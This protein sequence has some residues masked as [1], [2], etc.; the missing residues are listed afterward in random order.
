MVYGED[1]GV[2]AT[3]TSKKD[4]YL[5]IDSADRERYI[6]ILIKA[7]RIRDAACG[8][9]EITGLSSD[10]AMIFFRGGEE[11]PIR[12]LIRKVHTSY[13]S[14]RRTKGC[15]VQF[16]SAAYKLIDGNADIARTIKEIRGGFD[17]ICTS[18]GFRKD[19]LP[20]GT[21]VECLKLCFGKISYDALLGMAM[22][23]AGAESFSEFLMRAEQK[24]RACVAKDLRNIYRLTYKEIGEILSC[25]STTAHRIVNN[26]S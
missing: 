21:I 7:L 11:E 14:Y 17:Y 6:S 12:Y 8:I 5:F 13:A 2:L 25:S 3:V 18:F 24:Q 9:P 15:A 22:R 26:A 4:T 23:Y 19:G 1:Y 16:G 20:P 10:T